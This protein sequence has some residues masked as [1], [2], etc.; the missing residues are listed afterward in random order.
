MGHQALRETPPLLKIAD[1]PEGGTQ[2]FCNF[3][4]DTTLGCCQKVK[5]W[6]NLS[7]IVNPVKPLSTNKSFPF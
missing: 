7:I 1:N 5:N 2:Y 4:R 3:F 6:F